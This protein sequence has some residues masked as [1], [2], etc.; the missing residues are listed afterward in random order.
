MFEHGITK[1]KHL[2]LFGGRIQTRFHAG[3]PFSFNLKGPYCPK[4]QINYEKKK[5]MK[6]YHVELWVLLFFEL[7]VDQ[8]N[9][10]FHP[11]TRKDLKGVW[12]QSPFEVRSFF[13]F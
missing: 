9:S 7:Y 1:I 11:P 6:Y 4:Y 3:I 8:V 2:L 10:R 12:S 5:N 13:F